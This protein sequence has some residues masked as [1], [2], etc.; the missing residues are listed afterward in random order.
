[1]ARSRAAA[2]RLLATVVVVE[3]RGTIGDIIA[4]PR[5]WRQLALQDF[6]GSRAM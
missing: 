1:M 6:Q 5:P 3:G 4:F 2:L